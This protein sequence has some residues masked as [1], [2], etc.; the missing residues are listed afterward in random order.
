MRRASEVEDGV[1]W[2]RMRFSDA[3]LGLMDRAENERAGVARRRQGLDVGCESDI[4]KL[5]LVTQFKGL[6]LNE[7]GGA[8][9]A[10]YWN[11]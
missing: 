3:G 4:G 5:P 10:A 9:R 11:E 1:K 7:A 6:D 8:T 2:K